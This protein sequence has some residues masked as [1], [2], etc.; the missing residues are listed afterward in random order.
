MARNQKPLK[1]LVLG[2]D[3]YQ[4]APLQAFQAKGHEVTYCHTLG[5]CDVAHP[6]KEYDVIIGYKCHRLNPHFD[7][8]KQLTLMEKGVRAIKYPKKP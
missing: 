7:L 3:L 5:S 1:V 6:V 8:A 4:S 2:E